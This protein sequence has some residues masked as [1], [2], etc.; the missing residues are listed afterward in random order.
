[1]FPS[2]NLFEVKFQGHHLVEAAAGTGKTYSITALY[3]RALIEKQLLPSQILVLT[4]T[5][6]ATAE[7]QLRLRTRIKELIHVAEGGESSDQ[8]VNTYIHELSPR[9]I[10]HLKSCLFYF[11]EAAISTIH[12]FCQKILSENHLDFKI[13][14]KFDVETNIYP[15]ILEAVDIFWEQYF[16]KSN[17]NDEFEAWRLHHLNV[18]FKSP[19][20]LL[21]SIYP[22]IEKSEVEIFP[23]E[24]AMDKFEHIF[25][26]VRTTYLSINQ[27][28]NSEKDAFHSF[29]YSDALNKSSYRNKDQM[30]SDFEEWMNQNHSCPITYDKLKFFGS[31]TLTNRTK[32]SHSAPNFTF[33]NFVDDYI[34]WYEQLK[35]IELV[36]TCLAINKIRWNI[37]E[38]KKK[39]GIVGYDDLVLR[40][41]EGLTTSSVLCKKLAHKFPI[42]F[43]DEFQDTDHIQY[44]IFKSIYKA[45]EDTCLIMIGDPKQ[46]IYRFRGADIYTYLAVRK[47]IPSNNRYSLINNYRTSK[48]LLDGINAFFNG[49]SNPFMAEEL[50]FTS[51]KF[52]DANTSPIVCKKSNEEAPLKLIEFKSSDLSIEYIKN[53][54]ANSVASECI[55]LLHSDLHI[56]DK[57]LQEGDITILV[58]THSNAQLVQHTLWKYGLRSIIRNKSSVFNSELAN[59]LY[60]L[61]YAISYP[62]VNGYIKASL[63]TSFFNVDAVQLLELTD[64]D[65]QWEK[66]QSSFTDLNVQWFNEG[67]NSVFR[68]LEYE[69]NILEALSKNNN[70]ERL[71][72][73]YKHLKELLLNAERNHNLSKFGILRHFSSKKE[74]KKN[75]ASEDEIIRLES[76]EQLIQIVTHHTSKGLEYSIV[77]CPFLWNLTHKKQS[78]V[79][80]S[81]GLSQSV[82]LDVK[83]NEYQEYQALNEND[84]KA[85]KIRLVYVALTRAKA[86]CYIYYNNAEQLGGKG[87]NAIHYLMDQNEEL[88]SLLSNSFIIEAKIIEVDDSN[89][90]SS[91]TGGRYPLRSEIKTKDFERFD[92]NDYNRW[93]SFSSLTHQN[94]ENYN[95]E[96]WGFDF[97]EDSRQ[98]N[99]YASIILDNFSLPKGKNTGN[100]LHNIFE[101][102]DF[103]D[104]HSIQKVLEEQFQQLAYDEQWKRS[105]HKIILNSINHALTEQ[106]SLSKIKHDDRLVEMEFN[107]P[108]N[109][110]NPTKLAT[111]LNTN[112]TVNKESLT[113]FMKG[114]IDLIFRLDGKYYILDYKSNHLGDTFE[115]YSNEKLSKEMFLSRYTIQYH[116]YLIAFLRYIRLKQPN[117]DYEQNFGGII[118]LFVRGVNPKIPGSGVFFHKPK[119]HLVQQLDELMGDLNH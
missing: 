57:P 60:L 30:L 68:A 113:G 50:E 22:I 62:K 105:V 21:K 33:A 118:Y 48:N 6:D 12:G 98:N 85:E 88:E 23:N 64:D 93:F 86:M 32:Q 112:L 8:F 42:A 76:D 67:L 34:E 19:D 53:E 16:F 18:T 110:L 72:T 15:L 3:V 91:E 41:K 95:S 5:N 71:I 25:E 49:K 31:V 108:L 39:R 52:P 40:V 116:I 10:E 1:M 92:L 97:D 109:N 51:A 84:I 9:Q 28:F 101:H 27:Y 83:S 56:N 87:F 17:P 43:I 103:T 104:E 106:V 46:A 59:Q 66:F 36:F 73:D 96:D 94:N 37:Q 74:K 115:S 99:E 14:S 78:I 24:L 119:L 29:F 38:L 44:S 58:D 4:F 77:F 70:P 47:T 35:G 80:T 11:D 114:F 75:E 20:H 117:F 65:K 102:I 111:I 2:L 82:Y 13:S 107:F 7:L 54:I 26:K 61:L 89:Y 63:L 55:K 69:F 81:S 45:E 79:T 90:D 100:L